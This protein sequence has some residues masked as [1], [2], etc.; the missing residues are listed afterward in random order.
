MK[1]QSEFVTNLNCIELIITYCCNRQCYNCQAMVRQA[2]SKDAMTVEQIKKFICETVEEK[3]KWN[4]I[5]IM[6]GE[7]TLH[8]NI[9]EIVRLLCEYRIQY[10]VNTK[11][12]IVTNGYGD[13]VESVIKSISDHYDIVIENSNKMSD[14]HED[15][16]EINNAPLDLDLYDEDEYKRGC[17]ITSLCGIA[18]DLHGYY[19][20]STAAAIDRVVGYDIGIKSLSRVPKSIN[21][22]RE[23]FCKLCGHFNSKIND[24]IDFNVNG[25]SDIQELNAIISKRLE[26]KLVYKETGFLKNEIYEPIIS[27]FWNKALADYYIGRPILSKY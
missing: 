6:G 27:T 21:T 2:P 13:Y 20:C 5:R 19:M 11:I 9:E 14:Y 4:T 17:W 23:T 25:E 18:L 15:F 3:I 16:V 26:N 24:A 12:V 1:R 22:S 7:P 8:P 10:S